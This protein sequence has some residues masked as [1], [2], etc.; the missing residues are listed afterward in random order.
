MC[1][2]RNVAIR[3]H[4]GKLGFARFLTKSNDNVG[5]RKG[6]VIRLGREQLPFPKATFGPGDRDSVSLGD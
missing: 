3:L 6:M 5:E 2:D 4:G 1:N